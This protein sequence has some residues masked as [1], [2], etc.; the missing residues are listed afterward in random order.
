MINR[1]AVWK[2]NSFSVTGIILLLLLLV[3]GSS[4]TEMKPFNNDL[5]NTKDRTLRGARTMNQNMNKRPNHL[6]REKSPYLLQH[7]Y[8]PVEWYPWGEEA[9]NRAK[10]ENK[11]IFLSI[12][13]STCHWCHVMEEE[14]FENEEIAAPLNHHFICIKV[15]REERPD[16]DK[17]YM[18]AVQALTGSGGWPLNV[19]LTP[20]LEPFF[21]GT[22]F[23]PTD[24][25]G[26][27]GMATLIPKIADLWKN[28]PQEIKK[29][30]NQLANLIRESSTTESSSDI[31]PKLL[32]QAAKQ[33][34]EQFDS[35]Y[36]GFGQ[37]PKFPQ[38][39]TL[40]FLLRHHH[41]S[42]DTEALKIVEKT[43]QQMARGGIYDQLGGGF[44]RYSTDA[45]WLVP[46]FEK[47]LYDNAVLTM[48]Y[49]EAFQVTG[50]DEYQK[51]ARETLDYVLSEMT[52]PAGGFYSAQ[53][54][55]SEGE[56]GTYYV[57]T[58][59][60]V[61]SILGRVRAGTFNR[62]YDV[63]GGGN[64]EGGKSILHRWIDPE[65]FAKDQKVSLS[66]LNQ[67]LSDA[68]KDLFEARS[69]RVQPHRDDKILTA[70][71]GLMIGSFAY[72]AQILDEDRYA[73]AAEKAAHFILQHLMNEEEGLLRRYRDGEARFRAY[74]DD[75]AFLVQGLIELYQ[76]TFDPVWMQKALE[77]NQSMIERFYDSKGGGFYFSQT[78]DPTLIARSKEFYDGAKPSGNAIAV[79]NLLRLSEFTGNLMLKEMAVKT[80]EGIAGS[81]ASSPSAFAQSLTAVDFMLSSPLEIAVAGSLDWP[82]THTLLKAV[83]EPF[84][85]N[86]VVALTWN[87]DGE[88]L[89]S[90]PYLKGKVPIGG[91]PA[92]YICRN[93]TC[94]RPI[95]KLEEVKKMI[96]AQPDKLE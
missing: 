89:S 92:V 30:G 88:T 54:A 33:I 93:Y 77:I 70:W 69:Q 79:S 51:T 38:G 63:T 27:P 76:T 61:E 82:E 2:N 36:G 84:V 72:A 65:S 9:L 11:P 50:K 29:S 12:G 4:G 55:D 96:V 34:S 20:D 90:L 39:M 21:G 13:Y 43:L 5:N 53:D 25:W 86:K 94:K 14:S 22:Y 31:T 45:K 6:I 58:P 73:K 48:V 1:R 74:L 16:L 95:T 91:A 35:M 37:A 46:H 17:I 47:M 49:L 42:G 44:H 80:L 52:D 3:A 24:R 71:N 7:A 18:T 75:Y 67:I 26:R 8:N 19:F 28:N 85:P 66:E 62:Y 83:R 78:G 56:E 41:R 15:D 40:S 59:E 68:R 60:Q 87:G 81:L 64:F 32:D 57:W 10:K 23:P